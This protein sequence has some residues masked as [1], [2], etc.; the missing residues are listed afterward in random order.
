MHIQPNLDMWALH[1]R[2]A[3]GRSK[4]TVRTR[5]QAVA[6]V[7]NA[8]GIPPHQLAADALVRHFAE[9]NY[10]TWTRR[11]Y[12][13][14]LR[15]WA[16]FAQLDGVATALAPPPSPWA[17]PHPVREPELAR[18]LAHLGERDRLW[19]LLGAYAGL[20]SH[21][22]AQLR[23]DQVSDTGRRTILRIHGKR[24]SIDEVPMPPVLA[25]ALA[26]LRPP[27]TLGYVFP[28]IHNPTGHIT[29]K[30][31]SARIKA[32]AKEIGIHLRF[33]HLRHRYGTAIHRARGDLDLTMRRMRHR[34]PRH[35]VGY[36]LIADEES[37]AVVDE[38]PGAEG[39]L[40]A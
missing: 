14:S 21:E 29:P 4:G 27:D 2:A 8:L 31:V 19:V 23:W 3:K 22:V 12:I 13:T 24:D 15:Q 38:L 36:V 6:A 33:H 17:V 32:K 28:S 25:R 40:A 18:L 10:K 7:A 30:Y 35:T 1:L 11:S 26:D 5:I 16:H 20:R 39:D 37:H 9:A 34:N